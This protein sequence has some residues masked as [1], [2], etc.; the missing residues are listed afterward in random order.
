M[1]NKMNLYL[2]ATTALWDRS[3]CL[4]AYVCVYIFLYHICIHIYIFSI[5]MKCTPPF[6]VYIHIYT[7]NGDMYPHSDI[8]NNQKC[9]LAFYVQSSFIMCLT[10][11]RDHII[12]SWFMFPLHS[13]IR[14]PVSIKWSKPQ[15][16]QQASPREWIP[17]ISIWIFKQ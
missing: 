9:V 16:L 17:Q 5:Y 2:Q 13:V 8:I 1:E 11:H 7:Q 14:I 3:V 10:D 4:W 12:L 6:C 15:D